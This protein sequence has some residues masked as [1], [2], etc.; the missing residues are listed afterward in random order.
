MEVSVYRSHKSKKTLK[1]AKYRAFSEHYLLTMPIE[2]KRKRLKT[3]RHISISLSVI[4]RYNSLTKLRP[5]WRNPS[6][7]E[8]VT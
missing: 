2:K 6:V 1:S 8:P 4:L 7:P 3:S 5:L